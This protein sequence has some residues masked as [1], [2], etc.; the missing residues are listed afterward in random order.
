MHVVLPETTQPPYRDPFHLPLLTTVI[1]CGLIGPHQTTSHIVCIPSLLTRTL[2]PSLTPP[3][4]PSFH[5]SSPAPPTPF[6][7]LPFI[8]FHLSSL[9][10]STTGI[11]VWCFDGAAAPRHKSIFTPLHISMLTN[12]LQCLPFL[13]HNRMNGLCTLHWSVRGSSRSLR[14]AGGTWSVVTWVQ[15]SFM[16]L[17]KKERLNVFICHYSSRWYTTGER[18]GEREMSR[19][20]GRY[21]KESSVYIL[22]ILIHINSI[23]HSVCSEVLPPSLLPHQG[24]PNSLQP[25]STHIPHIHTSTSL[26]YRVFHTVV[27]CLL[28]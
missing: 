20:L 13:G 27:V 19:Q 22:Y 3:P 9:L 26:G 5:T 14:Y 24:T 10:N 4:I 17:P 1:S 8:S 2:P 18:E 16:Y 21:F 6:S 23:A 11:R 7:C 28:V 12:D 15:F 25:C